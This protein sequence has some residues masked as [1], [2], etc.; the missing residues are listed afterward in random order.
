MEWQLQKAKSQFSELVKQANS[1]GPQIVTVRGQAEAV[2]LSKADYDRLT[3][4][5]GSQSLVA[6]L[7][8]SPLAEYADDLDLSR[9]T[10]TGREVEL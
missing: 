8:Q 5:D 3:H 6:F 1:A 4:R 2:L 10:D 9:D 7:R